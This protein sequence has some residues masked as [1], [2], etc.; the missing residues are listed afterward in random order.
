MPGLLFHVG[1]SA[2]CPH[3]GQISTISSNTRVLVSG[4]PVATLA[5]TYLIAGCPFT[6]PGPKPQPCVKA[7]W[8]V[9]AMRVFING[10]PAILQT[11]TGICQSLEQIPQGPPT[12]VGSQPRVS[13]M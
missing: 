8:L 11:S 1:A 13:G 12:I 7:Q 9:P 3:A 4:Q 6:I 10:Q 2:I 5:D